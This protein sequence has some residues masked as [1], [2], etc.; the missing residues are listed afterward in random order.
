MA[1]ADRVGVLIDGRL[2]Q[3]DDA[4]HVFRAPATEEVARFVGVETIL[5]GRVVEW[6]PGR[7]PRGRRGADARGGPRAEPGERVRLCMR[8]EDVTLSRA[9]EP[10]ARGVQPA[11]RQACSG[12]IPNGPHVRVIIDCGFPLVALVTQRSPRSWA[13]SRAAR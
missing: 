2:A 5:E 10:A 3:V 4:A 12:S 7:G 13:S 9:P 8:P 6:T 11:G 1:L